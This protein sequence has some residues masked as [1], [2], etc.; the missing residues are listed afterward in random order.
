MNA[1][2]GDDVITTNGGDDYIDGG[3]GNDTVSAIKF[4]NNLIIYPKDINYYNITKIL[5]LN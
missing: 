3:S 1:K 2:G 5:F 4:K